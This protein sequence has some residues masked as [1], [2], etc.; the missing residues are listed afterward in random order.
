V[1][2]NLVIL[3]ISIRQS[4]N[5]LWQIYGELTFEVKLCLASLAFLSVE[6]LFPKSFYLK[7]TNKDYVIPL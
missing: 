7:S 3:E 1:A 5:S 2:R 6:V 4:Q